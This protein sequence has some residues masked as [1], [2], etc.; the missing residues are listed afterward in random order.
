VNEYNVALLF[1]LLGAF[2]LV[3]GTVI[4]GVAFEAARRRDEPAEIALLLGLTR[5]GVLLIGLGMLL[6]LAF[7]LWLV[8]LGHW[9]YGSSWVV[10]ALVLFALMIG[11]GAAGGQRPKR[12]RKLAA[13]LHGEHGGSTPELRALLDDRTAQAANLL[14]AL[15]LLA[16]IAIMVFKP[17]A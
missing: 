6:V 13:R 10:A 5:I 14:S 1:H 2:L 12:A 8:R 11:L 4:A 16:I 3:G 17:G 9:G 15:L 7:G